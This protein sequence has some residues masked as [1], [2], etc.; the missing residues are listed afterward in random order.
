MFS[1]YPTKEQVRSQTVY[2]KSRKVGAKVGAGYG[3]R[4]RLAGLG[5]QN[6]TTML[7]PR[8]GRIYCFLS[9][10]RGE[11]LPRLGPKNHPAARHEIQSQVNPM[12]TPCPECAASSVWISVAK[13]TRAIRSEYAV[14]Y[15]SGRTVTSLPGS[16]TP[17]LQRRQHG[18]AAE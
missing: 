11:S 1:P 18:A 15:R 17:S 9:K 8:R 16:S 2:G 6:I 5:S 10:R 13:V 12:K 4:T 7:T 14:T 3:N